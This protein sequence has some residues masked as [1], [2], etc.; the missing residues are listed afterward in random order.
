[1]NTRRDTLQTAP[2]SIVR[3]MSST[4][5]LQAVLSLRY[6]FYGFCKNS[7]IGHAE[8]VRC[9]CKKDVLVVPRVY[10]RAFSNCKF[11]C[12]ISLITD[13]C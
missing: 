7:L 3:W 11:M 1:M 6:H 2:Q 5:L 13:A 10:T 9:R 4:F 8:N 12:L